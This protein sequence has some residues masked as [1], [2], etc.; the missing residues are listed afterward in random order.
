MQVKVKTLMNKT[1]PIPGF[2]YSAVALK[3][4]ENTLELWVE[5]EAHRQRFG[6]CSICGKPAPTYDHLPRRAWKHVPLWGIVT[7]MFLRPR[8]VDCEEHGVRVEAL[9]WSNG[10][11]PWTL[12]M[13]VFLARWARR[14]SWREVA[15]VYQVSWE[16]VYRSV[17]WI[18]A[19]GLAR[20]VLEG[21]RAIGVDELHWRKGKQSKNFVTLISQV[22][23]GSR[24]L[25]WVGLRRTQRT[26]RQGLKALGPGVV[27]GI[28]V[29]VSDMWRA[30]LAVVR[31]HMSHAVQILDR[32]HLTALLNK[33]VDQV[34]RT[35]GHL[36]R[37]SARGER[38][39]KTRWLLLR[40][41]SRVRGKARERLDRVIRSKLRTA[42]AWILKEAFAHFW[43]YNHP[44]WAKAFL[45][46]WI[47][48]ALRSRLEPM[49]R[50]A[51]TLRSHSSLILNWF[52]FKKEYS[53]AAVEGMNNKIRVVT[54]RS[55]G[56][57]SFPVLKVALYH[58]LGKLPEPILPHRFC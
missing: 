40:P 50:V 47:T 32:F 18:V 20:R 49:R 55:Y 30:Y 26:F 12:S 24:R 23:A 33:A 16:A 38:L 3:E 43:T 1:Q 14:M 7:R 58:A 41:R 42:R 27:A 56:F 21:V 19:W 52:E 11:R 5:I 51:R 10:K 31:K 9:P 46:G 57:R 25:L 13:M 48:R 6:R 22:D 34:R 15:E 36:L 45:D 28:E 2:T 29:V 54:R 53:S 17:A 37:S 8:R 44:R 35:E 39:K 4:F